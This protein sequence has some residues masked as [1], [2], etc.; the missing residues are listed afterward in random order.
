[1]A[2]LTQQGRG[3]VGFTARAAW[4]WLPGRTDPRFLTEA[5]K[6]LGLW[7]ED[8]K[9]GLGERGL[10]DTVQPIL[11]GR[12]IPGTVYFGLKRGWLGEGVAFPPR[13]LGDISAQQ[14][15][16]LPPCREDRNLDFSLPPRALTGEEPQGVEREWDS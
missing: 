15:P 7:V 13:E 9:P 1:M 12:P 5:G 10:G 3:T 2:Q 14:P 16:A 11:G 6:R 4:L 8:R